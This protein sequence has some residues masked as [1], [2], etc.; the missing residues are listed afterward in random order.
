MRKIIAVIVIFML[1]LDLFDD[2]GVDLD[3]VD[4][5]KETSD[6]RVKNALNS[7]LHYLIV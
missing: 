6:R 4:Q 7:C 2:M 1:C 5:R 3:A